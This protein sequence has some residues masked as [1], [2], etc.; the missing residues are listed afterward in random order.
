MHFLGVGVVFVQHCRGVVFMH[1]CC[2]KDTLLRMWHKYHTFLQYI[3]DISVSLFSKNSNLQRK[4]FAYKN[5]SFNLP[6]PARAR[7]GIPVRI[8]TQTHRS[9]FLKGDIMSHIQRKTLDTPCFLG[10]TAE[11]EQV[12]KL[13]KLK[14]I[15]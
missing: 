13:F 14:L 6:H 12:V 15:K 8:Y 4:T 1:P 5:I 7:R 3:D 10:I 9:A 2:K 11:Q